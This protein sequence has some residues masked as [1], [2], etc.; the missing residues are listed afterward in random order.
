MKLFPRLFLIIT[1]ALALAAAVNI[2]SECNQQDCPPTYCSDPRTPPEDECCDTCEGASC[3]WRGCVHF[4]P[5][6]PLWYPDPCTVCHCSGGQ[7]VCTAI[8]CP[9]PEC[10]GY[11]L[12]T[13]PDACCPRCDWGIPEDECA[14]VPAGNMSLYATLGDG[15]QCHYEVVRHKCDKELL[16][17][18]NEIHECHGKKKIT[19]LWTQDCDDIHKIVYRDIG[20]CVVKRPREPIYDL[21]LDPRCTITV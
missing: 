6:G 12:V 3:V 9:V 1:A 17:I 7:E 18:N 21:D 14:P 13:D 15:A 19:S 10:F 20:R 11:P 4:G 2:T 8:L 16:L 5:S